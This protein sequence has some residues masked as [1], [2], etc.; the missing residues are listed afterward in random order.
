MNEFKSKEELYFSYYLEELKESGFIDDW[1]YEI[2]KWVLTDKVE[3]V[4]LKMMKSKTKADSK[5]LLH[6]SSITSDFTVFWN[7]KAENIFYSNPNIPVKDINKIPFVLKHIKPI[8]LISELESKQA[9]T[10]KA[11]TSD[12]S[13]P[14][15]QKFVYDKLNIFIQKIVPFNLKP[16]PVSLFYNTFVPKKALE[17]EVYKQRV[18]KKDKV[19]HSPGDSK[20]KFTPRTLEQFLIEADKNK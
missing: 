3:M 14:Y 1:G 10:F 13:F 7:R 8:S 5:F 9:Y 4:Y 6:P 15:K 11:N 17:D 2:H 20:F 18:K 12:V 16:K 19:I